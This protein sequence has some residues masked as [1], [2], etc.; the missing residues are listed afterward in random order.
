M[1]EQITRDEK[2]IQVDARKSRTIIAEKNSQIRVFENIDSSC[3]MTISAQEHA[4][5]DCVLMVAS[6]SDTVLNLSIEIVAEAHASVTLYCSA[7][8]AGQLTINCN[9]E[10]KEIGSSIR[11]DTV[12]EADGNAKIVC[13]TNI[14]HHAANTTSAVACRG[15]LRANAD[16][17]VVQTVT[18]CKGADD[19]DA[20]QSIKHLLLSPEARVTAYPVLQALHNQISCSHGSSIGFC[21]PEMIFMLQSKGLSHAESVKILAEAFLYEDQKRELLF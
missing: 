20:K 4:S 5:I 15:V 19:A 8:V 16:A 17:Q 14:V 21:D 1:T 7:R 11:Y 3:A 12:Y 6:L 10:Q 9:A 2:N 13:D 18:I